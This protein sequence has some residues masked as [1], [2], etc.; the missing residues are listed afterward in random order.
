MGATIPAASEGTAGAGAPAP[1][2][3]PVPAAGPR[4]PIPA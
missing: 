3:V 4:L 1:A 2:L